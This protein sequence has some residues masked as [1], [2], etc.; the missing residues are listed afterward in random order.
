MVCITVSSPL[1]NPISQ[2]V[3]NFAG[4]MVLNQ[5]RDIEVEVPQGSCLG[6]LLFLI[7][8][9]DLPLALQDSNVSMYADDIILKASLTKTEVLHQP[10]V[11]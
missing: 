3:I 2:I 9:N 5:T 4:L 1:L 8:I 7:Y 10:A 6:P 11:E